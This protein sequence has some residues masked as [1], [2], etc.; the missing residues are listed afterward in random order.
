MK[1]TLC[2][3]FSLIIV[4]AAF[5]LLHGLDAFHVSDAKQ[6]T[7]R[8]QQAKHEL[9]G[10]L[11]LPQNT[12]D[13]P[14]VVVVHGDGPQDRYANEGYLP[15]FHALLKQGIGVFSW[16]KPGIG[17][18]NGNWLS[19]TM[20]DR[21]DEASSALEKLRSLPE[22]QHRRMG[23]L[24][25]SQAGWVVP[26]INVPSD[27]YILVGAAINWRQQSL[28]YTQQR[29]KVAGIPGQEIELQIKT[30]AKAFD[31]EFSEESAKQACRARPCSRADFERRNALSDAREDIK[32]V[33]TP[34]MIL[35]G[36]K[37]LNVNTNNTI[38]NWD[39]LLPKSTPYCIKK[40][41]NATHGLLNATWFNFQRPDQWSGWAE[42]LFFLMGD[43]A[44]ASNVIGLMSNWARKGLCQ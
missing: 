8:F 15:L 16:D 39:V 22:L 32:H 43:Q 5:T 9:E 41:S 13:A 4:I 14:I 40:I 44:Y 20:K 6:Q 33:S 23:V 38:K 30:S 37:D 35:S 12:P 29:L 28:Y 21:A 10:T 34:T 24:G 31:T 36:T 11:L 2:I 18:S 7:L 3:V 26:K 19:Q 25:F 17:K 27:F 42:M 1:K